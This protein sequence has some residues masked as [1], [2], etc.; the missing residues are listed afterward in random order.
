MFENDRIPY[1]KTYIPE[2]SAF[3]L[4]Q[5]ISVVIISAIVLLSIGEVILIKLGMLP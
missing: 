3:G 2:P 5:K 4:D 1:E